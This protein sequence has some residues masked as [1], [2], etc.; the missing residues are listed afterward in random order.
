MEVTKE[1]AHAMESWW[2]ERINGDSIHDNGDNSL[3]S[4]LAGV[5]ADSMNEPADEEKVTKFVDVLT[6]KIIKEVEGGAFGL[7]YQL[8]TDYAPSRF[9][10]EAAEEA[11]I[12]PNN[13]PWK[14]AMDIRKNENGELVAMVSDGYRAGWKQLYPEV[15][16]DVL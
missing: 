16:E 6:E 10:R 13:F 5:L 9:L 2:G 12:N 4:V 14:T 7:F 11:G 15:K 3:S 8:S 1:M